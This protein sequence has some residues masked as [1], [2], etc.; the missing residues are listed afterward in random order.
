MRLSVLFIFS[1]V[2]A[3]ALA[4]P[5]YRTSKWAKEEER[6][7]GR[8]PARPNFRKH[9]TKEE[10]LAE[11]NPLDA[12]GRCMKPSCLAKPWTCAGCIL[13][14]PLKHPDSVSSCDGR[15]NGQKCCWDANEARKAG[16]P[17]C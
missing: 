2:I 5:M 17:K 13:V 10:A 6:R 4:L 15:K 9:V 3:L 1:L 8:R 11:W 7:F 12:L 14:D 16:L